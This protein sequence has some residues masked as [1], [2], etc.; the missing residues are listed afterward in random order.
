M[1]NSTVN[2]P[3]P[4]ALQATV[5]TSWQEF[6]TRTSSGAAPLAP[7]ITASLPRVW[8]CSDYVRRACLRQPELLLELQADLGRAY[9]P[10]ELRQALAQRLHGVEEEA[11]LAS[12]LRQ[13]RRREMVRVIW[14]DLSGWA[15][16]EETL[17]DLSTL[18]DVCLD[19]ALA[20]LYD[21]QCAELGI[22]RN[23]AGEAQQL[24]VIGMGK[25]GAG[26]LNLS[27]DIDLIF[28]Y[29]EAG[30]TQG[31][32]R[33]LSNSE[34]FTRL[35][36]RLINALH[37]ATAE[38][39]V[40]RVDMR[41]RPFGDSGALV[42]SFD[43]MESYYQ[44][45]GREWERFAMIKARVVAGDRQAG[46]EL[47]QM[48]RPFVFRRYLDFGA[49][50]NLREMKAMV[51]HEVKRKGMED[52]VKLGAG[53]IRE[54]EFIAQV[55]QIIRGGR[56]TALQ[57][58]RLMVILPALVA[59]DILPEYVASELLEAYRFL[60]NTEHRIQ[61]WQDQQTHALPDDDLGRTRLAYA[62]G[63]AD[64]DRF[65][66][67]L[68]EYRQRVQEQ[69]DQV[70]AAP[71]TETPK[72]E[73]HDLEGI[74]FG[75]VD[76]DVAIAKLQAL[77][78]SDAAGVWQ[79]LRSLYTG[80]QY[81][82]MSAQGRGRLD[83]LIPLMLRAVHHSDHADVVIG[84]VLELIEKV[85]RRTV[86]LSLLVE[87]PL[88]LSQLIRL[89]AAS[90]W[91]ARYLA[92]HP[93]LLDELMDPR[94]LYAPP[95]KAELIQDLRQ[96][97]VQLP[98]EDLEQALDSLRHFKQASVLSVAAADIAEVL[99]LMKV[100][101]HLTWIA[102][103]ILDEVLE[104]AWQHLVTRHGRPVCAPDGRLCDKGFAIIGYGKLGGIELGY[105]SDLDLVFIHGAEDEHLVTSGD[106][107]L[108]LQTFF[109]R[110]G[111]RIIHML[112]AHT[113]AGTLYEAD[114][115][116]RPDGASG[117]LVSSLRAFRDY[118]FNKAWVWE[119]QALVRARVVAGD[120]LIGEQFGRIRGE[121][122]AQRREPEAL[123][124]AVIEMR[125]KMRQTTDKSKAGLFDL[126]Q[127][128]G[129]I[130]DIEFMVQYGVLAWS[131]AHPVLLDYPDN[132]RLL[133][134]FASEG[135]MPEADA[136]SLTDAYR[137][138]RQYL[139]RM[140]LME[141]PGLIAEAE[142]SREREVVA[143]IW[144]QQLLEPRARD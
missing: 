49:Y 22:P 71:Q 40:F 130:V 92:Q 99:P 143:R 61:A 3:L 75:R 29:P 59:L 105:G 100:S 134:L 90:P 142:V 54:I 123:R 109:A 7:S 11:S 72:E 52:N 46:Q 15:P 77:G 89:C 93:I 144:Q 27:S 13:F 113:A 39:F 135:L 33:P 32:P 124:Q 57:D 112:T 86:Y 98:A 55:F 136:A 129:G 16:L 141:T 19:L 91:I 94:S 106:R 2:P 42:A 83:R 69:F 121:V 56:E 110:L 5:D 10:D 78:F 108:P 28:A 76:K 25:L 4:A 140:K 133:A 111:Q 87:N 68:Q 8:A 125:E 81:Q 107:P 85:A 47:M 37:Q 38:G 58:R 45:H 119:H 9:A 122:L 137:C 139:H 102:E 117:M 1:A 95:D 20:R 30:E 17:A 116:L 34:F 127:G 26:E 114:M 50:E 36:Q 126:K 41:L 14:R 80:R 24:V 35:G 128:P 63:F 43:A 115:R 67:Q 65:S 70:F 21:W 74:W 53:G 64:W 62:M 23:A 66:A 103:T 48:L 101:D 60:R 118:Q 131:H 84:R 88:A 104:L 12:T 97:L 120:P 96:R 44:I 79:R 51:A 18:A 132:V 82:A 6:R 138:Y 73:D 31:G